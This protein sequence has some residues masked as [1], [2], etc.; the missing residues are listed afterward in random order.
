MLPVMDK[1]PLGLNE[2]QG[3]VLERG[4]SYIVDS[5]INGGYIDSDS[6]LSSNV[7]FPRVS[8]LSPHE[9]SI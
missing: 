2:N 8:S 4:C 1:K 7:F 9:N 5:F 3:H 6:W